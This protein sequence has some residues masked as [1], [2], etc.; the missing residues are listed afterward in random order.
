MKHSSDKAYSTW[1]MAGI[2]L[3]VVGLFV[4]ALFFV[5][6]VGRQANVG[7]GGMGMIA[8]AGVC[9]GIVLIGVIIIVATLAAGLRATSG[10]S[11]NA[12]VRI[13]GAKIVARYA[14]NEHGETLF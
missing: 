5:G 14:I 2:G 6:G 13:D 10:S 3:I 4:G 9:A 8:V 7:S 1:L 12:V 11:K